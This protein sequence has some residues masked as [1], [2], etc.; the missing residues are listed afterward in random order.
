MLDAI[1]ADSLDELFDEIPGALLISFAVAFLLLAPLS[2]AIG[3]LTTFR[4]LGPLYRFRMFLRQVADGTPPGPCKIRKT[5]ELHDFCDLLNE[6]TE[7]LRRGQSGADV[8]DEPQSEAA[9][10]ASALPGQARSTTR[11]S[12]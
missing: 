4:V 10:P 8:A 3:V 5:D 7:P 6:V 9:Q 2:L 1:G 12:A 11:S